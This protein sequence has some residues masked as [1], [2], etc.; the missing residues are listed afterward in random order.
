MLRDD[1][2]SRLEVLQPDERERRDFESVEELSANLKGPAVSE[3]IERLQVAWPS[4]A[5]V[6]AVACTN[7][8]SVGVDIARLGLMIVKGQPKS[9]SE[10]IQATSRVGRD[11]RRP[12]GLVIA[13]YTATRPRDRSHYESFQSYHSALYRGVEPTTVTPYS[14]PARAR[15]L[16][17]GLVLAL[18]HVLGWIEPRDARNFDPHNP[19]Q[20]AIIQRLK[21]RCLLA[22][23]PDERDEVAAHLDAR[24]QEWAK[25]AREQ[26]APP[27]SF[28][29]AR[30]FR[31][32]LA[33]FPTD[34]EDPHGYWPTLNSMRHVDGEV[35]FVV[36]G[37]QS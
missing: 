6:D 16:H 12:P 1:V 33:Q 14:A 37:Q 11:E 25:L 2:R 31:G 36:R 3:A 18:R 29:E 7:M 26:G 32:L 21:E 30:Q 22:C 8:L 17:A 19:E 15:A 10:Y 23:R 24:V 27:L 5:T 34:G 9:T 35:L 13:L 4:P 20:S 28:S